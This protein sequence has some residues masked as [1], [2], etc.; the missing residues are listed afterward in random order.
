MGLTRT[1][2]DF[3]NALLK[4]L[5][6]HS[7]L[8]LTVEQICDEAMMHRSSFYR[9]FNDKSDLLK[10]TVNE[11]ISTLI[12]ESADSDQEI[13]NVVTWLTDNKQILRNLA[14]GKSNSSLYGTMVNILAD[15]ILTRYDQQIDD[16]IVKAVDLFANHE[17]GAYMLSS[18]IV[19][20]FY[21]WRN[22]DYATSKETILTSASQFVDWLDQK[23]P[24]GGA[25]DE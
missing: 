22:Q 18:S 2:R 6:T 9:Y 7:F 25:S 23:S 24:I 3:Q 5:T 15:I 8:S 11:K 21:W 13:A 19:G 4:L 12:D 17:T 16:R 20:A 14:S 10:H 1:E